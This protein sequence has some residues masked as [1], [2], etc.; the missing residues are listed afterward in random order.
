ML[1]AL[2]ATA[3]A[4]AFIASSLISYNIA[5]HIEQKTIVVDGKERLLKVDSSDGKTSSSYKNFVYAGGEAYVV[6]DSFWNW[7]FRAG[8]VYA[9][10]R[11]GATCQVTLAGYRFGFLS[12]YQNIIAANCGSQEGGA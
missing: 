8:T 3:V 1:K 2:L 12:M 6:E 10:L 11:E 4:A 7:H 9:S 5:T